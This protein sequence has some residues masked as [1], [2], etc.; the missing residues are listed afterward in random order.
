[1]HTVAPGETLHSIARHYGKP[2]LLLAKAN[3]IAPDTMVR[4][5]SRIVIPGGASAPVAAAPAAAPAPR[6]EQ[7]TG[8]VASAETARPPTSARIVSPAAPEPA[9]ASGA[10][11]IANLALFLATDDSAWMTG[12]SITLDGGALC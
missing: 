10:T 2:V 7:P 1:M 6:N 12:A 3:N 4:V 11:D 8:P 5:G 9:E